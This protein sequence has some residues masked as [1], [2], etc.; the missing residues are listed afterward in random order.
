MSCKPI[1][2]TLLFIS[3]TNLLTENCTAGE[4]F[5]E[6]VGSPY[7]MAPEVLR[8]SYGPEADIWSAGVILYILLCGVPPFWAGTC[9]IQSLSIRPL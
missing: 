1:L 8:R 3:S 5:T 7:Y 6:I 9:S 4:R 2:L